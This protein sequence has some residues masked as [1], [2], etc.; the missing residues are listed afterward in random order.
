M[1]PAEAQLKEWESQPGFYSVLLAVVADHGLDLN[2]R[3]LA[4]LCVKNGVDR[5]WRKTATNAIAD[6][7][8]TVIRQKLLLTLNEPVTQVRG[9]I[10][11]FFYEWSSN[12]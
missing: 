9:S 5:Y 12:R 10:K 3:W 4:T 11:D 6:G 8:K 2:V 7:E 1:K